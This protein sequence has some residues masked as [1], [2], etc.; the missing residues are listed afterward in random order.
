MLRYELIFQY[1]SCFGETFI[2]DLAGGSLGRFQYNSC[3]GETKILSAMFT[4]IVAFQYNS[5]FGETFWNIPK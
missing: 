2:D 1:N 4:Y 3:F 5:C